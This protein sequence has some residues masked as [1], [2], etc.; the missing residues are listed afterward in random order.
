M[1][2]KQLLAKIQDKKVQNYSFLIIFFLI[3][4]VFVYFGIR[5][6]LV[7]AFSLNKEL[8]NLRQ[9][10]EEYELVIISIVNYQSILEDVRDEFYLLEE[11]APSRPDVYGMIDDIREAASN[12]GTT[13]SSIKVSEIDLVE[14]EVETKRSR[15]NKKDDDRKTYSVDFSMFGSYDGI[16]QFVS[17]ITNQR[18]IKIIQSM[19]I[20]GGD[21]QS[22]ES[23]QFSVN[24]KI[25]TY[26]L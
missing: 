19:S 17:E 23:A 20:S 4:A 22:T 21:Q 2:N 10:D 14:E 1:N 15:R 26:Y 16:R 11:A 5:P 24:M 7:T 12:S 25:E 13:V 6:N 9:M 3:F 18:R 8:D